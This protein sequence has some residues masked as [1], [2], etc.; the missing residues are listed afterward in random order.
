MKTR[1]HALHKHYDTRQV[2]RA[3]QQ[4][5]KPATL[6]RIRVPLINSAFKNSGS[7]SEYG[8]PNASLMNG[9]WKTAK[10]SPTMFF[11]LM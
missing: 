9:N 2:E 3:I 6:E 5:V 10:L 11:S 8:G 1:K 4:S 7:L